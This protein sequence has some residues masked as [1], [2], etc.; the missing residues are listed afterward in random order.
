MI[1][2]ALLSAHL[3]LVLSAVPRGAAAALGPAR[4]HVSVLPLHADSVG[5]PAENNE[6]KYFSE[7]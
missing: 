4:D 7:Q 5:R 2:P 3:S 6:K 1:G